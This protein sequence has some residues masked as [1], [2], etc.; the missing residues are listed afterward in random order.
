MPTKIYVCCCEAVADVV[1]CVQCDNNVLR[2]SD[3]LP[4]T[5]SIVCVLPGGGGANAVGDEECPICLGICDTPYLTAC[6]HMFCH[7]CITGYINAH[8]VSQ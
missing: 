7:D 5:S 4:L 2:V 8:Q 3:H 1:C 6:D